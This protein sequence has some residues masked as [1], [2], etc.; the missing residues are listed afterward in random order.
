MQDWGQ[1]WQQ[2]GPGAMFLS[3]PRALAL[4]QGG[5]HYTAGWSAFVFTFW[6]LESLAKY[7]VCGHLLALLEHSPVCNLNNWTFKDKETYGSATLCGMVW[8]LFLMKLV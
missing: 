2:A 6:C 1:A 3:G 8:K 5:N 7:P 4:V